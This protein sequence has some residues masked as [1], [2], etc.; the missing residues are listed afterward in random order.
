MVPIRVEGWGRLRRPGRGFGFA[1][2]R[3]GG[4][5]VEK[6]GDACVALVLGFANSRGDACVALSG[7][8]LQE[9]KNALIYIS[10]ESCL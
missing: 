6:G 2:S 9:E 7:T 4:S 3:R 10:R 8:S 5:G 1:N